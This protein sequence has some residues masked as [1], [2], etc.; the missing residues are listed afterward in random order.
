MSANPTI[1]KYSFRQSISFF[2]NSYAL[3]GQKK[4]WSVLIEVCD[5]WSGLDTGLGDLDLGAEQSPIPCLYLQRSILRTSGLYLNVPGKAAAIFGYS[6]VFNG[7]VFPGRSADVG[8]EPP[9]PHE[10]STDFDQS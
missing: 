5:S 8:D 4:H 6:I 7:S 1:S 2:H 9:G 10:A 3:K